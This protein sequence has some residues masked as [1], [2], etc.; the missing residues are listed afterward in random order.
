MGFWIML[1]VIVIILNI[2]HEVKKDKKNKED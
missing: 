1:A 2:S